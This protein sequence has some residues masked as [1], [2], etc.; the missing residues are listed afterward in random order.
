MNLI[1]LHAHLNFRDFDHDR[2][3]V[4]KRLEEA[5]CGVVNVGVDLPTSQAVI[6]LAEDHE[7]MW[8]TVG[9]HPAD[10][11]AASEPTEADW[12]HLEELARQPKVVAI[13]ECGLDYHWVKESVERD[14]QAEK[15]VRQIELAK[16]VGKPLMLHIREAYDEALAILERYPAAHG[17]VH[18]FA[19]NL[20]QA[21][22]FLK[23]GFT[24][25]VT[26]VITFTTA[27]DEIIKFVPLDKLM[28]ETDAP[29]VA[30]APY[31]G[32]RN[33]PLY[34]REVIRKIAEIKQL[35]L[36]IVQTTLRDNA[37]AFVKNVC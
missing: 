22:K 15:F 21:E 36:E 3:E 27:Y 11:D 24:I 10:P 16:R 30:P 18:F 34:V 32:K 23:R 14:R 9:F 19:G 31:R 12:Q 1:D 6:K 20:A 33:E 25:S 2:A 37:L 17:N 13:G 26:G 28:A 5:R 7:L 8:A 29:F 4:I 35:P